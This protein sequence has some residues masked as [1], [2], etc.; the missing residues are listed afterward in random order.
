M[1]SNARTRHHKIQW[2]NKKILWIIANCKHLVGRMT[3]NDSVSPLLAINKGF[4]KTINND[5]GPISAFRTVLQS[6]QFFYPFLG[7]WGQQCIIDYL[8]TNRR[9]KH[10]EMFEVEAQIRLISGAPLHCW[11]ARKHKIPPKKH[12]NFNMKLT[13]KESKRNLNR[14]IKKKT[15]YVMMIESRKKI[16][17]NL[18]KSA[19]E[20]IRKRIMDHENKAP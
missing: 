18:F 19:E 3:L 12:R 8:I 17:T 14:V 9:F 16:K 4:H 15:R 6:S 5:N 13:E 10:S 1:N 2:R 11:Y 20:A 7:T